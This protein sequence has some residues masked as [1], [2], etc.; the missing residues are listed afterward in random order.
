MRRQKRKIGRVIQSIRYGLVLIVTMAI[1]ESV[2]APSIQRSRGS[3]A[4]PAVNPPV[5]ATEKIAP[6]TQPKIE[7]L[8]S[9]ALSND[10]GTHPRE[11]AADLATMLSP[12]PVVGLLNTAPIEGPDT[13]NA[14]SS[15]PSPQ[16]ADDGGL[17]SQLPIPPETLPGFQGLG[18]DGFSEPGGNVPTVSNPILRDPGVNRGSVPEPG[19]AAIISPWLLG[20]LRRRVR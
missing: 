2:H 4:P 16:L 6:A 8:D 15:L 14:D 18:S 5:R 19:S 1:A 11:D 9:S 3:S 17:E 13:T 12:P 7:G 10:E 20:L